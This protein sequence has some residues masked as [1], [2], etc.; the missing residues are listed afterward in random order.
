[1]EF[2]HNMG[3]ITP[4]QWLEV[5]VWGGGIYESNMVNDTKEQFGYFLPVLILHLF[6]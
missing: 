3:N 5:C 4:L 1:M 6:S 2:P